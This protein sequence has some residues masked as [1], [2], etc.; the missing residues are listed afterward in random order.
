MSLFEMILDFKSEFGQ[1]LSTI[2]VAQLRLHKLKEMEKM[3]VCF[4]IDFVDLSAQIERPNLCSMF[5]KSD[6][7]KLNK[8]Y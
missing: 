8:L 6:L 7:K 2:N 3:F 1:R 5:A 4:F